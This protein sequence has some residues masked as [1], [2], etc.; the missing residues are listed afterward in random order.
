[1]D[2]RIDPIVQDTY[3]IFNLL[4]NLPFLRAYQM[5][6]LKDHKFYLLFDIDKTNAPAALKN[7]IDLWRSSELPFPAAT[8]FLE[9]HHTLSIVLPQFQVI[10]LSDLAAPAVPPF[11][12]DRIFKYGERLIVLFKKLVELQIGGLSI[13]LLTRRFSCSLDEKFQILPALMVHVNHLQ[14]PFPEE[15]FKKS[16]DKIPVS[17][18]MKALGSLF[19]YLSTGR[20]PPPEGIPEEIK[21]NLPPEVSQFLEVLLSGK[22]ESFDQVSGFLKELK[23]H[24][25]S[26]EGSPDVLKFQTNQQEIV[27]GA[28]GQ[29]LRLP[30][31]LVQLISFLLFLIGTYYWERLFK[32]GKAC[33]RLYRRIR[34]LTWEDVKQAVKKAIAEASQDLVNFRFYIGE[35]FPVNEIDLLNFTRYLAV[36]LRAGVPLAR[37]LTIL[38]QQTTNKRLKRAVGIIYTNVVQKGSTLAAA[39]AASPRIF[40]EIYVNMVS[41]GEISGKL[42]TVL[43]RIAA[44]LDSAYQLRNRIKSA[45]RYPLVIGIACIGL[46]AFFVYLILP[47]FMLIFEGLSLKLPLPTRILIAIVNFAHSPATV[48][49]TIL[50]LFIS[51]FPIIAFLKTVIGREKLD[52]A[53]L[54]IPVFGKLYKKILLTRFSSTLA[55]LID[56]GVPILK[57]LEATG[58]AAGNEFFYD[59]VKYASDET[60]VGMQLHA[61]LGT[62]PFFPKLFISMLKVGEEAGQVS[63]MLFKIG[64]FYDNEVNLALQQFLALIEPLLMAVMGFVVGFVVLAIFLPVYAI[65]FSLH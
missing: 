28:L 5:L 59:M 62:L 21:Q 37:G 46:F 17:W 42:E 64:E 40:F 54:R 3:K 38:Y 11:T 61:T 13:E 4:M 14:E 20:F 1:M 48:L 49:V 12:G 45:V 25:S 16:T 52:Q 34:S 58:K 2:K 26:A 43:G 30:V 18:Y 56:C 60:R 10:P 36:M 27:L 8:S 39:M 19:C 15:G 35:M 23:S 41:V 51:C 9:S 50:I 65:V 24:S 33:V 22:A 32:F 53:K 29:L 44:Y 55:A 63:A 57:G 47:K 7:E 31:L 6:G